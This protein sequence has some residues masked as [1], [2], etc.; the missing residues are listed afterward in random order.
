MTGIQIGLPATILVLLVGASGCTGPRPYPGAER[1]DSAGIQIVVNPDPEQSPPDSITAAGNPLVEIGEEGVPE[2]EFFRLVGVLGLRDGRI[3][4][5]N[6]GTRELRYY[7]SDGSYLGS[8]GG[9]GEG[10]GEFAVLGS[11]YPF[12]DSLAVSDPTLLRVSILN[13]QGEF[14]R[15][16]PFRP[17]IPTPPAGAWSFGPRVLGVFSDGSIMCSTSEFVLPPPAAGW[18]DTRR[19]LGRWIP[20]SDS[21]IPLTELPIADYYHGTDSR[22]PFSPSPFTRAAMQVLVED[23]VVVSDGRTWEIRVFDRDGSLVR[24]IREDRPLIPIGRALTIDYLSTLNENRRVQPEEVMVQETLPTYSRLLSDDRGRVWARVYSP[25]GRQA[26]D[27]VVFDLDG[28]RTA[29]LHAPTDFEL[30]SVSNE[31]LFGWTIDSLGIQRI[32]VLAFTR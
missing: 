28:V 32:R 31:R 7:S 5:V 20:E 14:V 3:L 15:S 6:S 23:H 27:W 22:L 26:N 30:S 19:N 25:P 17:S 16:V 12:G 29:V 2:Y 10:P 1:Y 9:R 4:A 18:C 21:L 13:D 8:L 11:A 24:V